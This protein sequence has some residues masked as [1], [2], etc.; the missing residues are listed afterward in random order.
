MLECAGGRV[1]PAIEAVSETTGA[2]SC[3]A[4]PAFAR[5]YSAEQR[6]LLAVA[7]DLDHVEDLT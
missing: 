3:V 5:A 6:V 1:Q 4:N 7:P 2:V